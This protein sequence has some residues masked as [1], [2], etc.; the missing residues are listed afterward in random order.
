MLAF[1]RIAWRIK[2]YVFGVTFLTAVAIGKIDKPFI[3][4][5]FG[6][7]AVS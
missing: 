1:L 5:V 7:A 2:I 4:E 3:Y 6:Y